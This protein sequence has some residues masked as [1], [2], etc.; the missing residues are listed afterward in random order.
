MTP[1]LPTIPSQP[2]VAAASG[3]TWASGSGQTDASG[4]LEYAEYAEYRQ[5]LN[6]EYSRN[7]DYTYGQSRNP[8]YSLTQLSAVDVRDVRATDLH[9]RVTAHTSCAIVSGVY[10]ASSFWQPQKLSM[11]PYENDKEGISYGSVDGSGVVFGPH[12]TINTTQPY[13]NRRPKQAL[14]VAYDTTL[15][16]TSFSLMT[17]SLIYHPGDNTGQPYEY[18]LGSESDLGHSQ[19]WYHARRS[20]WNDAFAI[21]GAYNVSAEPGYLDITAGMQRF[22][23]FIESLAASLTNSSYNYRLCVVQPIYSNGSAWVAEA[24]RIPAMPYYNS[25]H[26]DYT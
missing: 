7:P 26:H 24:D 10:A 4:S 6:I 23:Q 8:Y 2:S 15:V 14:D 9:I 18:Y 21:Y 17:S 22:E 11:T 12:G 16:G 3:G 1:P 25:S 5:W 19:D 20:S 13:I